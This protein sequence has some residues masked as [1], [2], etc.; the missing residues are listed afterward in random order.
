M[1]LQKTGLEE[2]INWWLVFLG[3][4]HAV[5]VIYLSEKQIK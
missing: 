1:G 5:L 4:L 3:S 2:R